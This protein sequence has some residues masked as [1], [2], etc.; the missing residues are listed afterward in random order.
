MRRD[1]ITTSPDVAI[2]DA[3]RA[4][5]QHGLTG[6][7]VLDENGLLVGVVTEYD[8]ASKRGLLVADIMSRGVI[9][10][11]PGTPV[12]RVVDL[13]GLHGIRGIP[14]L[15]DQRFVGLV[16]RS[17]LVDLYLATRWVCTKCGAGDRG[18]SPPA[19][20]SQ[21]AATDWRFERDTV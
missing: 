4:M 15:Q 8:V 17:D 16:T 3:A 1:V 14:V 21:C 2:V 7:P 18:I 6:I 19:V 5:R 12:T 20:C 11:S 9:T 10:V 13:V